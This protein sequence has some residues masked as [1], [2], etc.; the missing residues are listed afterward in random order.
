M[1]QLKKV[2]RNT[3]N[4]EYDSDVVFYNLPNEFGVEDIVQFGLLDT[5]SAM[6]A[7]DGLFVF[8]VC[9]LV[10]GF[11]LILFH[12]PV[13]IIDSYIA[14]IFYNL[15]KPI[16][17]RPWVSTVLAIFGGIFMVVGFVGLLRYVI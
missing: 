11:L 14:D 4:V 12:K 8:W 9:Y 1:L 15:E 7:K 10:A 6:E 2:I 3:H 13:A 17:P 16:K 5:Y